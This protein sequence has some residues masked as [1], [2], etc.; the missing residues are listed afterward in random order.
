[1]SNMR[2]PK[3]VRFEEGEMD[4]G[5]VHDS[6]ERRE[7]TE[8]PRSDAPKT[9][10][11][12]YFRR[13]QNGAVH[14]H[15]RSL[16]RENEN[17]KRPKTKNLIAET[18]SAFGIPKPRRKDFSISVSGERAEPS[19][20]KIIL[21]PQRTDK[22]EKRSSMLFDNITPV[23]QSLF[24]PPTRGSS[25][26]SENEY[27][28]KGIFSAKRHRLRQ[29]AA[30][31]LFSEE[32]EVHPKGFDFV[33]ALMS[34][35]FHKDNKN[36]I[37]S[38]KE[39]AVTNSKSLMLHE[40]NNLD[41]GLHLSNKRDWDNDIPKFTS[42]RSNEIILP[43]RHT[44]VSRF[45]FHT[46]ETE[47]RAQDLPDQ[48][49]LRTRLCNTSPTQ[50]D[51]SLCAQFKRYNK[52][53]GSFRFERLDEF[54]SITDHPREGQLHR[55]FLESD[56]SELGKEDI[57]GSFG[58][59][60]DDTENVHAGLPIS[61]SVDQKRLCSSFS[62]Y[63]PEFDSFPENGSTSCLPQDLQSAPKCIPLGEETNN[64]ILLCDQNIILGS[65][66]FY[67]DYTK[68]VRTG[69]PTSWST[70]QNRLCSS[71]SNYFPEFDSF[72]KNSSS[73]FSSQDLPSAPK[74]ITL[75]K[76]T[77]NENIL[78]EQNIIL[79]SSSFYDHDTKNECTGFPTSWGV[80]QK[81]F[82][83]SFSNYFP[84]FDSFPKNGS[85]SCLTRDLPPAPKCITL[86]EE[87]NNENPLCDQNIILGSPGFYDDDTKNV[88]TGNPTYSSVGQ[89]LLCSSFPN[90]F[91]EFN[92]LMKND[93]TGCLTQDLPFPPKCIILGEDINNENLLCEQ[94]TI[95]PRRDQNWPESDYRQKCL[96]ASGFSSEDNYPS[97]FHAW[98]YP[99]INSSL[100]SHENPVTR[101]SEGAFFNHNLLPS[102]HHQ[103]SLG[104]LVNRPFMLDHVSCDRDDQELYFAD[105]DK[106]LVLR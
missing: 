33:A 68:N 48:Q 103:S 45:P 106:E 4:R 96:S 53:S 22:G 18:S 86:E 59:Y 51:F 64:E 39:D 6:P 44:F 23:G 32:A 1:M 52:P 67:D 105:E 72:P 35:L 25:E 91:P 38:S 19:D 65:S 82:F 57:L 90:Y 98:Q 8:S 84:E 93:S 100:Y 37:D 30:Q 81:P 79:G 36:N 24:S 88:H 77:N 66:S 55:P 20:H 102:N 17:L 46:Y 61:W 97:I 47:S 5:P 49:H 92:S 73:S 54:S 74:C 94:N 89:K 2:K 16:H 83:S 58:C 41:T 78:C 34:R 28:E 13:V 21:T 42:G 50:N 29:W 11:F 69:F 9:S 80:G 3:R 75:G 62:N 76:E 104:T 43:E 12:A 85:A 7:A 95:Y 71:F 40:S 70:V 10:E 14:G 101:F 26:N 27:N 56:P 15:S 63:F 99:Q 87:A 31:T 60:D